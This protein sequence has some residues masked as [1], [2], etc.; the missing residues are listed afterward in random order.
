MHLH[1]KSDQRSLFESQESSVVG[2]CPE[3]HQFDPRHSPSHL[4]RSRKL[5][6]TRN[7]LYS[8]APRGTKIQMKS[9]T[10]NRGSEWRVGMDSS[11]HFRDI[12]I[13]SKGMAIRFVYVKVELPFLFLQWHRP[14]VRNIFIQWCESSE[15]RRPGFILLHVFKIIHG[16]LPVYPP[17]STSF[18]RQQFNFAVLEGSQLRQFLR[19]CSHSRSKGLTRC[20][21]PERCPNRSQ[22]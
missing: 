5:L 8:N 17:C 7:S 22:S 19:Y 2:G 4:A 9:R 12:A 20:P 11:A 13:R 21:R 15:G 18:W 3:I 16:S 1:V 10:R 6:C 14:P